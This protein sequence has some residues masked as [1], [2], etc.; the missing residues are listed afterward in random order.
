MSEYLMPHPEIVYVTCCDNGVFGLEYLLA[1][2]VSIR[3]VITIPPEVA[4][5]AN[6]SGYCDVVPVCRKYGIEVVVLERYNIEVGHLGGEPLDLLIVNGWNRLIAG[7]VIAQFRYG[8]LGVH[9]GHP[10]I[11]LG[12]APLPWN[13]IKGHED[14]EVY[15]FRLTAQA[16]DGDIVARFPVEITVLDTAA[17]LYEK[18]MWRTATLFETALKEF[19]RAL[20]EAQAQDLRFAVHYEKREPKDGAIDFKWSHRRIHDFVRA[21][22]HPYPGAYCYLDGVSWTIWDCAPFDRF[23]FR[24]QQ[25]VPGEVLLALPHGLVVA[26][27]TSPIWLTEAEAGGKAVIPGDLEALRSFVG[28]CFTTAID[29]ADGTIVPV[30][31]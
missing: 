14:L 8:G 23:S 27:G 30:S 9:A 19:P 13:I 6:V 24:E 21:Q 16:D 28:R 4:R 10:P 20:L 12:R 22:T 5:Q 29:K 11:G 18:V 7:S 3:R 26:T 1:C 31:G 15:V 25:R 2:G 17:T